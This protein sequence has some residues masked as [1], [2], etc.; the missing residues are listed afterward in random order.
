M[1]EELI[2]RGVT[3]SHRLAASLLMVDFE[4][5]VFSPRRA[6]PGGVRARQRA[7]RRAG[8][9]SR[10]A[11]V[12]RRAGQRPAPACRPRR[13]RVPRQPGRAGGRWRDEYQPAAIAAFSTAVAP[14]SARRSTAFAPLFELAESR[15]REF[16]RRPL[17]EFRLTT[18][19][20]NIPETAPL[21]EFDA[22]TA[23]S[24]PR[25]EAHMAL[26][27]F[28]APGFL[29]DL[30]RARALREWSQWIAAA[31]RRGAEPRR[32]RRVANYGPRL[33]FFNPL[34]IAAGGRRGHQGHRLAGVPARAPGR[35]RPPTASAGAR[36][37]A[38]ATT[39]TSTASGA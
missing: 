18:P 6:Q 28:D 22:P 25:S 21:L 12:E 29:D 11:F 38:A 4:N 15:R 37:T 13:A 31:A 19:T 9:R 39:R 34:R 7:T 17:A 26:T 10:A 24:V 20:T 2:E 30:G 36:P 8:R 3:L 32:R 27:R 23:A 14:T 33:Q 5:P 16:R 1:L 35:T